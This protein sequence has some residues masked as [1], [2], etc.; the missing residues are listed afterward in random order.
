MVYL[1]HYLNLHLCLYMSRVAS[2]HLLR[3]SILS[4]APDAIFSVALIKI[5]FK[6]RLQTFTQAV[7]C[8]D[9]PKYSL[10]ETK[11]L[12]LHYKSGLSSK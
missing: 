12:S 2:I 6:T 10:L 9:I 7:V 4:D 3:F 11:Q 1:N 8:P 5:D